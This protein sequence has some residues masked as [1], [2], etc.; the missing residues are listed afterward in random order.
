MFDV[1]GE[2]NFIGSV[3]M[4]GIAL[5]EAETNFAGTVTIEGVVSINGDTNMEGIVTIVGDTNIEGIV[6]IV[7]DTNIEGVLQNTGNIE[8][9]GGN[10]NQT[11]INDEE[12]GLP[13][14]LSNTLFDTSITGNITQI[15][16][17]PNN[18]L[19]TP[20][21]TTLLATSVKSLTLVDGDITQSLGTS[22]LYNLDVTGLEINIGDN[23]ENNAINIGNSQSTI[24][25]EGDIISIGVG[26][27][28]NIINIGNNFT[29][30]TLKSTSNQPINIDNA[31]NQFQEQFDADIQ[32]I[33]NEINSF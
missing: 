6:T 29:T 10:I 27:I 23:N 15:N 20:P 19:H 22:T 32:Q 25:L 9:I 21:T 13:I 33:L 5:F 7:G 1:T 11:Q 14:P 24:T 17:L 3:T 4:Q 16:L 8:I 31:M 2:S 30:L 28:A 12:T 18:P 26:S